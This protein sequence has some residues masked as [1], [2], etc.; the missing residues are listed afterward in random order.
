VNV[1]LLKNKKRF[2]VDTENEN[3][4]L[5][6]NNTRFP[7]TYNLNTRSNLHKIKIALKIPNDLSI[8][9]KKILGENSS[10]NLSKKNASSLRTFLVSDNYVSLEENVIVE[11]EKIQKLPKNGTLKNSFAKYQ[12][13][14]YTRK[15]V[16]VWKIHQ[17]KNMSQ[18]IK[19]TFRDIC[20]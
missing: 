3:L 6:G 5:D 1:L 10:V 12:N 17:T 19:N 9:S 15:S 4:V 2:L 14:L 18:T 7:L 8:E 11:T 20:L 13:F 16:F